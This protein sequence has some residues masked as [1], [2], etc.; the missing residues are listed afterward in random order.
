[1][2][3]GWRGSRREIGRRAGHK[4]GED[5]IRLDHRG[6]IER[7]ALQNPGKERGCGEVTFRLP[8]RGPSDPPSIQEALFC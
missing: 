1:M 4:N 5:R 6:P 3:G 8:R 7:G 2:Q